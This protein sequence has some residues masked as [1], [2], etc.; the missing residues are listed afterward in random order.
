MQSDLFYELVHHFVLD[1]L[2]LFDLFYSGD[3]SAE[4]M[5]SQKDLT[6]LAFSQRSTE[7][8]LVGDAGFL[9]LFSVGD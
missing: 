6:E 1:Y 9:C 3:E 4:V 2:F 5:P 7:L 8:E